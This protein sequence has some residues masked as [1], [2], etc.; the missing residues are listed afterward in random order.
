MKNLASFRPSESGSVQ[1]EG[2]GRTAPSGRSQTY[3]N[4]SCGKCKVQQNTNP[5]LFFCTKHSHKLHSF[6]LEQKILEH[7]SAVSQVSESPR[8]TGILRLLQLTVELQVGISQP[9]WVSPGFSRPVPR[10]IGNCEPS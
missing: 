7:D 1:P 2:A 10:W 5:Q 4:T 3:Q 6:F 8:K 9:P